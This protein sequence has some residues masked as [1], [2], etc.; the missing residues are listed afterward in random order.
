MTPN[1]SASLA[2]LDDSEKQ[3][4]E[5]IAMNTGVEQW[6]KL[7]HQF[8]QKWLD[9]IKERRKQILHQQSKERRE[10]YGLAQNQL[11]R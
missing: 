11:E 5:Y 7:F 8:G 2:C 6:D 10:F 9:E 3:A 1:Y 4:S